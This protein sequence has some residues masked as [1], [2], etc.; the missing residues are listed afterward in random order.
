MTHSTYII[1]SLL[2]LRHS[3]PHS[4]SISSFSLSLASLANNTA[5]LPTC[6]PACLL[7]AFVSLRVQSGVVFFSLLRHS[8]MN[9]RVRSSSTGGKAG[10]HGLGKAGPVRPG[11]LCGPSPSSD[12]SI[13][14][15]VEQEEEG[16]RKK[17]GGGRRREEDLAE[18]SNLRASSS[19]GLIR[20]CG[21]AGC[22]ARRGSAPCIAPETGGRKKRKGGE[23]ASD[24]GPLGY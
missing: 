21:S 9:S 13:D 11:L 16:G 6:V 24:G 10:R 17:R 20:R 18:E 12:R 23:R 5:C 8:L 19:F 14:R 1:N 4:L 22:I 7:V 3:L 2:N 15:S